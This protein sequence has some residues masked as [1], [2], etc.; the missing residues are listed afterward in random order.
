MNPSFDDEKR[1]ASVDPQTAVRIGLAALAV[2]AAFL[3]VRLGFYPFWGD[4]ADTVIFARGA[5]ETGDLNA[6]YGENLYAYRNG[7]LLEQLKGRAAPPLAYYVAAPFWGLRGDDRFTMRLPFALCGLATLGVVL[8][9]AFVRGVDIVGFALFA[10]AAASNTAFLLYGRQCRYF[11]L[12]MLLVAICGY[13]YDTYDGSRRKPAVL[14]LCLM[15]LAATHYLNFAAAASAIVVDYAIWRRRDVSL[16]LRRWGVVVLSPLATLA[17]LA[18]VYHPLGKNLPPV[19]VEPDT[20]GDRLR[21]LK[22]MFLGLNDN[23]FGVGLLLLVAP[24]IGFGKRGAA[25]LRMFTAIATFV[26][27]TTLLSP[28]PA[29]SA[30]EPDVRYL[31][32]LILPGVALSVLV[33]RR[34]TMHRTWPAVVVVAVAAGSNVLHVPGNAAA[35]RSTIGEFAAELL[36]PRSVAGEAVGEWLRANVRADETVW[37][38]PNEW[39]AP[40]IIQAPHVRYAWQLDSPKRATDYRDLPPLHFFPL[41]PVDVIVVYGFEN[42]L[43]QVRD[44]VLPALRS[45]GYRYEQVAVIDRFY[46]DRTRPEFHWHWFRDRAYDKTTEAVYVFRRR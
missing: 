14:S 11:A 36:R 26:V 21:L 13:C 30:I 3:F 22:L 28:Q 7:T 1:R 35:W 25:P 29:K 24:L 9:W 5:W 42:V 19:P 6:W 16:S 18:Y 40:Q 15:L 4:E 27:V 45:V 33:V 17:A 38:V 2:A 43:A 23:E 41:E 31:A 12:G 34:L 44:T 20:L 10:F 46:D 32:P 37:L 39:C 8:R